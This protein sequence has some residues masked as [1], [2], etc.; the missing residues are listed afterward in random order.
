MLLLTVVCGVWF[1]RLI[2]GAKRQMQAAQA[3]E[4]EGGK[5]VCRHELRPGAN[6]QA[7]L[8][9]DP[10]A[11]DRNASPPHPWLCRLVGE[12]HFTRV[13]AASLTR[14]FSHREASRVTDL[15]YLE[16]LH[17]GGVN[18]GAYRA[19]GSLP[20]LKRLSVFSG[21]TP[22]R[23]SR[24][25]ANGA[26]ESLEIHG[27]VDGSDLAGIERFA[28]LRTLRLSS[29]VLTARAFKRISSLAGLEELA[30]NG[31]CLSGSG[32]D[33]LR[34][35]E[36]LKA[37]SLS[38]PEAD[39]DVGGRVLAHLAE[40]PQLERLFLECNLPAG[41]G[42]RRLNKNLTVLYLLPGRPLDNEDIAAFG[43]LRRLERLT[44]ASP[45]AIS[46]EALGTF[47]R[48]PR[49]KELRLRAP[50]VTWRAIQALRTAMPTC[51]I[52]ITD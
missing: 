23:L 20:K 42:L 40:L 43:G 47:K 15:P 22:F 10:K 45:A 16:E 35:M 29:N 41:D 9:R 4:A 30:I 18:S 12:E 2:D 13:V 28:Q 1:C 37:L 39:A 46:D 7:W 5:I 6:P 24:L 33:F 32:I 8:F 3:I 19:L 52:A 49:L 27:M 14:E 17:L 21:Q 36:R 25:S 26:L 50:D 38:D 11:L 31:P 51:R 34:T 44:V 48:M